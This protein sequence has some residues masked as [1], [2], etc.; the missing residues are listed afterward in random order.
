MQSGDLNST[1]EIDD[2]QDSSAPESSASKNTQIPVSWEIS[3]QGMRVREGDSG[4]LRVI[5]G[6]VE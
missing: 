4:T 3:G 6:E 1:I 5:I 2:T